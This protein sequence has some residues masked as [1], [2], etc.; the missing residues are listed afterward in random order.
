MDGFVAESQNRKLKGY[1]PTHTFIGDAKEIL[2]FKYYK[3]TL[4][5]RLLYYYRVYQIG[6][7]CPGCQRV[8]EPYYYKAMERAERIMERYLPFY[9]YYHSGATYQ[10]L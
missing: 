8:A 4:T 10:I 9:R 6:S 3:P 5:G 7:G 2:Y 1:P